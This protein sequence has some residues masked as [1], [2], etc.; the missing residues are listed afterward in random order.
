M[1]ESIE[2]AKIHNIDPPLVSR[3][4][5]VIVDSVFVIACL[6]VADLYVAFGTFSGIRKFV[7][8]IPV[9]KVTQHKLTVDQLVDIFNRSLM[10]YLR[11]VRCIQ[12]ATALTCLLR[13]HGIS[14]QFTV[15]C[16]SLPFYSHA[17]VTVNGIAVNE[18][19]DLISTLR[20]LD[21][22]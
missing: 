18:S 14:A 15:G 16:R 20:V 6:L 3:N 22:F 21:V 7:Q 12:R 19:T 4:R 2:T 17:W 13:M 9:R 8:R 11:N 10:L 5:P 1:S